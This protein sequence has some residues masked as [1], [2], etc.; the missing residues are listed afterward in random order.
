ME[1]NLSEQKKWLLGVHASSLVGFIV[2]FGG[3]LGPMIVLSKKGKEDALIKEHAKAC[4]NFN[5]L[6][7]VIGLLF[8]LLPMGLTSLSGVYNIFPP[9]IL[10]GITMIFSWALALGYLYFVACALWNVLQ[11]LPFEYPT[12][13]Q[14]VSL[15]FSA[16]KKV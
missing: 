12:L 6:F 13:S 8:I 2:P 10:T 15:N 16:T 4:L 11:D 14:L 9:M 1:Q 5:L 3:L 7:A